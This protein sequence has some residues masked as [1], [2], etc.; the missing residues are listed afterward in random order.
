MLLRLRYVYCL[1]SLYVLPFKITFSL[2]LAPQVPIQANGYDCGLFVTKFAELV[3]NTQPSS[4]DADIASKFGNI[5]RSD[6]F[7]QVD[8]DGERKNMLAMIEG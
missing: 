8:V 1:L 5:L 6:A 4:T 7:S 2:L 3:L